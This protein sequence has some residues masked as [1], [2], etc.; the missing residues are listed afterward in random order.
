MGNGNN[1][2]ESFLP[3][4]DIVTALVIVSAVG[5]IPLYVGMCQ[6]RI[7][8][9]S[10]QVTKI[11]IAGIAFGSMAFFII[12]LFEGA[13][14]L[15]VDF[16]NRALPIQT[17]LLTSFGISIFA[18]TFLGA[19]TQKGLN[20]N[21][22]KIAYLFAVGIGLHGFAEGVVMGHGLS[23]GYGF[24]LAERALQTL[25]FMLHKGAEGLTISIPLMFAASRSSRPLFYSG[26]IGGLPL[27]LGTGLGI[28]GLSGSAASYAFAAGA[29]AVTYI[30]YRIVQMSG[31]SHLEKGFPLGILIGVLYIYFA[32]VIHAIEV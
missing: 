28:V 2:S 16:G 15:G 22:E 17:G 31:A 29:G 20:V 8:R 30:L 13:S 14:G 23:S 18:L 10:R 6:Q 3:E 5:F 32:G 25:S 9:N 1:M 7:T 24:T 19:T 11:A 21:H 12:D 26:L 4:M 27:V